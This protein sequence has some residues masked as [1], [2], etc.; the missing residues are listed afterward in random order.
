M[1]MKTSTKDSKYCNNAN[2]LVVSKMKDEIYDMPIRDFL[3]LK[4]STYTFI[5][6]DNH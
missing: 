3:G 5:I 4:S 2:N 6:E 1:F